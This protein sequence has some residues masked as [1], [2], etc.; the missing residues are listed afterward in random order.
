MIYSELHA[1]VLRP[2][3]TL[4]LSRFWRFPDFLFVRR[5]PPPLSLSLFLSPSLSLQVFLDRD[6]A[7]CAAADRQGRAG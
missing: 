4:R 1:M 3:P 6:R 7:R 5:P 2:D